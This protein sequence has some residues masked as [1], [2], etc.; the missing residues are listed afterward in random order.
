M[1]RDKD[2]VIIFHSMHRV[3]QAEKILK[4]AKIDILLIPVPRQ[5][6]SDCGLAIRY[7]PLEAE[8]VKEALREAGLC[9]AECYQYAER[10]YLAVT[11]D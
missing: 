9:P 2:F 1:V 11:A 4:R 6:S 5:L 7:A 10:K 3:M 8:Q